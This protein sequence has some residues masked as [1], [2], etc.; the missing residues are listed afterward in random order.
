V[1]HSML[2]ILGFELQETVVLGIR[3]KRFGLVPFYMMQKLSKPLMNQFALCNAVSFLF[4]FLK[5][6]I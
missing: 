1:N 4:F 3:K 5:C 6:H 2:T